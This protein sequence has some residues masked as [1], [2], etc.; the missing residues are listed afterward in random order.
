MT[1]LETLMRARMYLDKLAN[2][3]DPIT[4]APVGEG[5]T[6]RNPRIVRC[7]TYVCGGLDGDIQRERKKMA[8][9]L[10]A[11]HL[12]EH[13]AAELKPMD[14]TVTIREFTGHINESVDETRSRRLSPTT[15]T[16]WLTEMGFL[17]RREENRG[18]TPTAT[19]FALGLST[20]LRTGAEG[21]Y[22]IVLYNREAQQ[23]ILD[24]LGAILE[25]QNTSS[26]ENR[27]APWTREEEWFLVQQF[28]SGAPLSEMAASLKR[29]REGIRSHLKKLGF[30]LN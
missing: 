19:G 3:I 14:K 16:G 17:E 5:D 2:G 27:G 28:N 21:E 12:D 22:Y 29:T 9:N 7:L 23:F 13:R 6:V 8:K 24:H 15:I 10:P 18:R 20:E 4:N 30:E 26:K 11:F 1:E 25:H